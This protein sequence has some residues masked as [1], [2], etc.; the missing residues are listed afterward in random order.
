[1]PRLKS[2]APFLYD[3][4]SEDILGVRDVDGSEFYFDRA[5]VRPERFGARFDGVSDDRAAIQAAIDFAHGSG[6]GATFGGIVA[7]PAGVG[8][9]SGPLTMRNRVR[10]IGRGKRS[11]TIK[12]TAGF[13]G[14]AVL[15]MDDDVNYSFD[16]R[17]EDL[18][19]DCS[20]IANSTG[21]RARCLQE[22]SGAS[23]VLVVNYRL[24]GIH[25]SQNT[26]ATRDVANTGWDDLELYCSTSGA[27]TGLFAATPGVG[28][29]NVISRVTVNGNGVANNTNG[30][31]L[32]SGY[33][34]LQG[35]HFERS[36]T[37]LRVGA[38]SSG[39]TMSVSGGVGVTTVIR[40]DSA[41][42]T[43][44]ETTLDVATN[45]IDDAV[46][47]GIVWQNTFLRHYTPSAQGFQIQQCIFRVGSGTP[48]G[49]VAARVGSIFL[50]NNGGANTT[51]Y[52]KESGTGNT[53]W[54]AK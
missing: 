11:T 26:G 35:L 23:R 4:N 28:G 18:T 12:A 31:D 20:D 25:L 49:V 39:V 50:R 37:G 27:T 43:N 24:H 48:E 8:M 47:A 38:N 14:S 41:N 33:W 6:T 16:S 13:S 5:V 54:I 2:G 21:I 42:W 46:G 34:T 7:L 9:V 36:T 15:F 10:M 53:G 52:V 30:F 40:L 17:V 3:D 51:L 22:G 19:I 1:M 44:L 32:Q 45:L 29:D